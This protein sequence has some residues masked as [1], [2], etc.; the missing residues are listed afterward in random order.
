[1]S[2]QNDFYDDS[3]N[4]LK[5]VAPSRLGLPAMPT[6]SGQRNKFN[7]QVDGFDSANAARNLQDR[8]NSRMGGSF[9]KL[10]PQQ[11]NDAW[12]NP[13]MRIDN[14]SYLHSKALGNNPQ[15]D[16]AAERDENM[17]LGQNKVGGEDI[18]F[19]DFHQDYTGSIYG[20][21]SD[22][23]NSLFAMSG[24]FDITQNKHFSNEDMM[25][26]LFQN[27]GLQGKSLSQ[28]MMNTGA[29]NVPST[30]LTHGQRAKFSSVEAAFTDSFVNKDGQRSLS[31]AS[32]QQI[33]KALENNADY[34]NN[35]SGSHV[36]NTTSLMNA[37][38]PMGQDGEG[39]F[40]KSFKRLKNM[41]EKSFQQVEIAPGANSNFGLTTL[42][43]H[44]PGQLQPDQAYLKTVGFSLTGRGRLGEGASLVSENSGY[45][46]TFREQQMK[47]NAGQITALRGLSALD[48]EDDR[49]NLLINTLGFAK[50]DIFRHNVTSL[51]GLADG[52]RVRK[53]MFGSVPG[54][55]MSAGSFDLSTINDLQLDLDKGVATVGVGQYLQAAFGAN[56]LFKKGQNNPV[57][58]GRDNNPLMKNLVDAQGNTSQVKLDT[59][60]RM[61]SER[62]LPK[63]GFESLRAQF[64]QTLPAKFS[65]FAQDNFRVHNGRVIDSSHEAYAGAAPIDKAMAKKLYN[66][67]EWGGANV[68]I[69]AAMGIQHIKDN[70]FVSAEPNVPISGEEI[71]LM[72]GLGEND[73]INIEGGRVAGMKNVSFFGKSSDLYSNIEKQENGTYLATHND[74]ISVVGMGENY[75]KTHDR[76]RRVISNE[77]MNTMA[78]AQPEMYSNIAEMSKLGM[79]KN[80]ARELT[81][82]VQAN[83]DPELQASMRERGDIVD[84]RQSGYEQAQAG[85]DQSLEGSARTEAI[86]REVA[87]G[88]NGDRALQIGDMTLP[89]ARS[90]LS[91]LTT[92]R[93]DVMVKGMTS[94]WVNAMDSATMAS[95]GERG[96]EHPNM[97]AVRDN[98]YAAVAAAGEVANTPS[99]IKKTYGEELKIAGGAAMALSGLQSNEA[100]FDRNQVFEMF[101]VNDLK[102]EHRDEAQQMI[103][104]QI[105]S[106]QGLTAGITMDP[107]KLPDEAF[108]N[109]RIALHED[110]IK[111]KGFESVANPGRGFYT[112][113]EMV[114]SF[115]KDLDG[116][117]IAAFAHQGVHFDPSTGDI[118]F[119]GKHIKEDS[120]EHI[121]GLSRKMYEEQKNNQ[122]VRELD[123]AAFFDSATSAARAGTNKSSFWSKA[124]LAFGIDS[125][126]DK[127]TGGAQVLAGKMVVG[128]TYNFGQ[129]GLVGAA[130]NIASRIGMSESAQ[131]RVSKAAGWLAEFGY[132]TATKFEKFNDKGFQTLTQMQNTLVYDWSKDEGKQQ[133]GWVERDEEGNVS[134]FH[135]FD[136]YSSMTASVVSAYSAMGTDA[137][138]EQY[139][140]QLAPNLA[141]GLLPAN[142]QGDQGAVDTMTQSLIDAHMSGDHDSVAQKLFDVIGRDNIGVKAKALMFGNDND[143]GMAS[144]LLAA[145]G[146]H[147]LVNMND[148]ENPAK[149]KHLNTL[150][151]SM[152]GIRAAVEQTEAAKDNTRK[153]NEPGLAEVQANNVVSANPV[154][155]QNTSRVEAQLGHSGGGGTI[156]EQLAAKFGSEINLSSSGTTTTPPANATPAPVESGI[157]VSVPTVSAPDI[158]SSPAPE[159]QLQIAAWSQSSWAEMPPEQQEAETNYA[160]GM[161]NMARRNAKRE[162]ERRDA[163]AAGIPKTE[164]GSVNNDPLQ[165]GASVASGGGGGTH[166]TNNNKTVYAGAPPAVTHEQ[167]QLVDSFVQSGSM[168]K[169]NAHQRKMQQDNGFQNFSHAQLREFK[170]L[171]SQYG[172]VRVA[173]STLGREAANRGSDGF[174]SEQAQEMEGILGSPNSDTYVN[175]REGQSP[176]GM[177]DAHMAIKGEIATR[178]AAQPHISGK[179]MSAS[180]AGIEGLERAAGSLDTLVKAVEN[181]TTVTD[182][183]AKQVESLSKQYSAAEAVVEKLGK[184]DASGKIGELSP[185]ELDQYTRAKKVIG[186]NQSNL[187]TIRTT[188]AMIKQGVIGKESEAMPDSERQQRLI[189]VLNKGGIGGTRSRSKAKSEGM[190]E[191]GLELW[192][193]NL[194]SD[195]QIEAAG[196]VM[197]FANRSQNVLH[198]MTHIGHN[199]INPLNAQIQEYGQMEVGRA[200]MLAQL[201]G[202]GIAGIGNTEAGA[203]L[204]RQGGMAINREAAN[205]QVYSAY[206]GFSGI[207]GNS[208]AGQIQGAGQ[209]AIAPALSAGVMMSAMGMQ[210]LAAPVMATVGAAA[211]LSWLFGSANNQSS[212]TASLRQMYGTNKGSLSNILS[213]A[214]VG[215]A[216]VVNPAG[217]ELARQDAGLQNTFAAANADGKETLSPQEQIN[218]L[219]AKYNNPQTGELD[220]NGNSIHFTDSELMNNQYTAYKD[221]AVAGGMTEAQAQ[222]NYGFSLMYSKKGT[223]NSLRNYLDKVALGGGDATDPIKGL[224]A[225]RGFTATNIGAIQ[226]AGA[227]Y[228]KMSE[229]LAGDHVPQVVI[230][231]NQLE[232]NGV[233]AGLDSAAWQAGY[234]SDPY[235][236]TGHDKYQ[237]DGRRQALRQLAKDSTPTRVQANNEMGS[238]YGAGGKNYNQM[239]DAQLKTFV[240]NNDFQGLTRTIGQQATVVAMNQMYQAQGGGFSAD[241]AITASGLSQKQFS[242]FTNMMNGDART[243]S[244]AAEGGYVERAYAT[245]DTKTGRDPYQDNISAAELTS[246][247]KFDTVGYLKNFSAQDF[248][249]GTA[250]IQRESELKQ[251]DMQM[252]QF[253]KGQEN[254]SVQFSEMLGGGTLNSKGYVTGGDG[255][256]GMAQGFAADGMKFNAGDG[257]GQWQIEDSNTGIQRA[258]TMFS[259][260]QQGRQLQISQQQF[261][262]GNA[263]WGQQFALQTAQFN[264]NT[265]YQRNEM[266]VQRGQQVTQQDWAAQDRAYSR[267]MSDLQ[268]GFQMRDADRNIRYSRGRDRLDQMRHRDDATIIHAAEMG[269][270]D[271]TDDRAKQQVQWATDL[272]TRQKANFEQGVVFQKQS[273]DLQKQ[274][275]DMDIK[276]QKQSLDMQ[277]VAHTMALTWTKQQFANEDQLRLLTRQTQ[278][279]DINQAN[280]M[281]QKQQIL[282]VALNASSDK[283]NGV[284]IAAANAQ[285]QLQN[286]VLKLGSMASAAASFANGTPASNG[287]VSGGTTSSNGGG[288]VGLG[289]IAHASSVQAKGMNVAAQSNVSVVHKDQP[290]TIALWK[291]V[292][293]VLQNIEKNPAV[294]N[295]VISTNQQRFSMSQLSLTDIAHGS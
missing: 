189:E 56:K 121:V 82:S 278:V 180:G 49:N 19:T 39:F 126:P 111:R 275:H 130:R 29:I 57:A 249:Q 287:A 25:V 229:G 251:R 36:Y 250:G 90:A 105:R 162:N 155:G 282:Q 45:L 273:M 93:D 197:R 113:Q 58:E 283:L 198:A 248:E 10:N 240:D 137:S 27:Y 289:L 184:V 3:F 205:Q 224:A 26:S 72:A 32:T 286:V 232:R 62:D 163:V 165:S 228:Q 12:G 170:E 139:R 213:H 87:K 11:T 6:G 40:G 172:H 269:Q 96:G 220:R 98:A 256:K 159:G 271:K 187:D 266:Q 208:A 293:A 281:A 185:A 276:F 178:H 277:Q 31:M 168:A 195:K 279:R 44:L 24:G 199:I 67:G 66:G 192:G 116:D 69:M 97:G 214:I 237:G 77:M 99:H 65:Q 46:P 20:R 9:Q 181:A 264:Y 177:R 13:V 227:D 149:E 226:Q 260:G 115:G 138:D 70:T 182:K 145:M 118:S 259:L 288:G 61:P 50:G 246:L 148:S 133:P 43:G 191:G 124:K 179:L 85:V 142:M 34:V 263:M 59:L 176:Q 239:A 92:G 234:D 47:L 17:R 89:S 272:Y 175:L 215:G 38:M 245:M 2:N 52:T 78:Y 129:R 41:F 253:S 106:E 268:Y 221:A 160:N 79:V 110:V 114:T 294:V 254:R 64:S 238:M 194:D 100:V 216:S 186:D 63:A 53:G 201:G 171:N 166:I 104:R 74:I 161:G 108:R 157:Q 91:S 210:T 28:G 284:S 35:G 107:S 153:Y 125:G 84:F 261:Q 207:V 128:K 274:A 60:Q 169:L 15:F 204:R 30:G 257:R 211:S 95:I 203:I 151:Q 88:E 292:L 55:D 144:P 123:P 54:L 295:A 136:N 270:M 21:R 225:A 135:K 219:N 241:T 37:L 209:A 86:L 127:S 73:P 51:T 141:R 231:A 150:S 22:N 143:P 1:M 71:R 236:F 8:I 156:G 42:A 101:G 280:E 258:Q 206:A 94:A 81:R 233:G 285:A 14:A 103:L 75:Q 80:S 222:K 154:T 102:S 265:G 146:G 122:E 112:S 183:H 33:G 147:A 152:Q 267:N 120:N 200:Q 262:Q 68:D 83:L 167:V 76:G 164:Y 235:N 212:V 247:K 140:N 217:L 223:G 117:T 242:K 109:S 291:Q 218:T 4:V 48:N 132:Q 158:Q 23:A 193:M 244:Q 290:E 202:A 243:I 5:K 252:Y 173:M 230:D 134:K 18:T 7:I 174:I 255:L 190:Y 16:F 119:S 188:D 196:S 131:H